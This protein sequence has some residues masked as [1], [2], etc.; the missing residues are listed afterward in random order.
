MAI[1]CRWMLGLSLLL[2]AGLRGSAASS[3]ENR[4][5]DAAATAFQLG[6][7]DRAE[8]AFG[9]FTQVFTNSTRRAEA[10]LYQAEARLHQTNYAGAIE[11]LSAYQGSAGTNADQ[12]LFWLAEANFR[13]GDY[14]AATNVFARLARDFP[15][16]ARGLEAGIGEATARAKLSDWAGV[17]EGLQRPEGVFQKAVRANATNEL[18]SC[19]YLLLSEAQFARQDY[20]AAEQALAPLAR[21]RLAPETAWQRQY[22]R[23]RIQLADGRTAEVLQ[24][25]T[26]LVALATAAAQLKLEADSAAFQAGLLE[27]LG[28]PD[29]ALAIYQKN[30]AEGVPAERRREALWKITALFLAQNRIAAAAQ[31]LQRFLDQDPQTPSADMALLTLGEVRLRQ[32]LAGPETNLVAAAATNALAVT[33]S[34][35]LALNALQELARRFPQSPLLGQAYL[36]LGWCF[37]LTN[38]MAEARTNFQAA[39]ERLPLSTNLATAY[40][41]L[42]DTEFRLTN[43]VGAVTHYQAIIEKF[44]ALPEVA[45]NLFEPTLYQIVQA[46]LAAGDLAPVTNALAKLLAWYPAGFHTKSALLL[47]GQAVS[48]QGDS[49]RARQMYSDFVRA[50]PDNPLR[51]EVELAIARTYEE[52]NQW[53]NAIQQ[54]DRWLA[55]FTNSSARPQAEFYRAQ[56]AWQAGDETNAL[57]LFTN[58]VAQFPTHQLTPLAQMWA[59]DYYFHAGAPLDAEKSYKW[60]FQTNRPT[61]ELTY[62][63]QMMAGRAAV[64]RQA[65]GEARGYF[66]DL[67]NTTNCA[68]DLRIQALLACGD[69][70]MSQDSTN[71]AADYQEAI[72]IFSRICETY[73]TNQLAPLAWGGKANALWQWAKSSQRYEDATNAFQ[74][75]MVSTNANIAA[76]SQAAVGLALV[77]EKLAENSGTNRTALLNLALTNCLDVLL[78]SIRREG[79][80]SDLFWTKE[81]GLK[82]G[83]LAELLEAWSQ[84]INVYRKLQELI[85][86]AASKFDN[87]RSR[88]RPFR[89]ASHVLVRRLIMKRLLPKCSLSLGVVILAAGR[90]VRMGKPK[91][92]LPWGRTSVLGHLIEQWQALGAKQIAAVCAPGNQAIQPELDRL[93][94]SAENRIHNP[95]P[96]RGMFSS[97]QCAAKW[98]GWQAALTHW[99][100]VLG[101]QPHLRPATLRRLLEFSA[102]QPAKACQPARQGRGRHPV[103]LPKTLFRQLAHSTAATLKEFLTARPRQVALCEVDD[104]GIEVDIDRPEDYDKAVDLAAKRR[105]DR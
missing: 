23:C 70:Y 56:A 74:Q 2:A 90:S 21:Q 18:V 61:S 58:F 26:N 33:N 42:A 13:K 28:R 37:W 101:D 100:I 6:F 3:A 87:D 81:A 75:V 96:E 35:E 52:E 12:Y 38:Q 83:H 79:E 88:L 99:A 11:L 1:L 9:S 59:G 30:L 65:W 67:Y 71:K 72:R 62:Q 85:P 27:R 63:A 51:P 40:F 24:S 8:A 22:L 104:P 4:A 17:I 32:Y 53:T 80:E 77:L 86:A 82:A 55:I 95:V 7:Y 34:L 92:L 68:T 39:V 69:C 5:F 105:A 91:L 14:P 102:A 78:G 25:T 98:P 73:P 76:R 29:E 46:G 89:R 94:F 20:R 60:L 43:Y 97:I 16:S 49:A 44:R 41:K 15:S 45:T 19:G 47:A 50:A 36:D 66:T 31:T 64:A 54:Y 57:A 84:A 103:L 48:R 10:I 93:R